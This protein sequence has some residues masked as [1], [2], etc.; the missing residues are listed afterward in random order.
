[1]TRIEDMTGLGERLAVTAAAYDAASARYAEFV[2]GE[3]QELPLD[4]A[5]LAAFAEHV[6]A[7]G[8]GLVAEAGCGTGRIG[9]HLAAAGLDVFGVDLSPALVGIARATYPGLRV[10]VAS[11]HALPVR[12]AALGGIVAWYSV[13]HAAPGDVPGYFAEFARVL[14]PGGFALAA[15]FEA[16]GEPV[17]GFAHGVTPAYRW[18]LDA[19]AA[20][21]GEAGLVEVGRMS[22]E[23]R[24]G[25][26]FR[27]GHL[28]LRRRSAAPSPDG[29]NSGA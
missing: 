16:V 17:T 7:E 18:P 8:G 19:L 1:M 10:S 27:R 13:I 14:R 12:D 24:P 9:A 21:A 15:F 4:R 25:E 3:L 20:L 28:L 11:M 6:L 23:P 26:R 22:R 5:V 29:V 2:K